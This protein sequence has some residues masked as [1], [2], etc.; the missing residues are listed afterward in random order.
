MPAAFDGATYT[1]TLDPLVPKPTAGSIYSDWKRWV[2]SGAGAGILPAF[3]VVGGDEI[4]ASQGLFVGSYFF[5]R[6]DIGWRVKPPEQHGEYDIQGNFFPRAPSTVW[7]LGT[8]G[9]FNTSFD[10]TVSSLVTTKEVN[11]GSGVSAQDKTDIKNLIYGE[12]IENGETLVE[13]LR[14]LRANAAGS[15]AVNADEHRL[16]SADGLTDRIVA[17]ADAT[18]RTVTAINTT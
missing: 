11:T 18:G 13:L 8:T 10:R 9:N 15:I 5:F 6:N 4:D 17:T 14:L 12:A 7:K 1:V 2:L 16:K 3:D